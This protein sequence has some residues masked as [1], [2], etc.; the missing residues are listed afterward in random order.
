ML[1]SKLTKPRGVG[2][3]SKPGLMRSLCAAVFLPFDSMSASVLFLKGI[4]G[5]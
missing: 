3:V 5:F 4:P 2:E 1:L